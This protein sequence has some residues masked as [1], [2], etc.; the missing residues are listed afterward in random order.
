MKT[1]MIMITVAAFSYA[2]SAGAQNRD[3]RPNPPIDNSRLRESFQ[4]GYVVPRPPP[5]PPP[6][7]VPIPVDP[8]VNNGSRGPNDR[9]G[10]APAE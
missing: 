10:G 8:R 3:P 4:P 5:A 2:A 6:R 1:F 9:G 7:N